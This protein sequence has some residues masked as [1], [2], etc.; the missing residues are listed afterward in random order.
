MEITS[1]RV[2]AAPR[3]A[4]YAAF[5]NPQAVVH[6]WGPHGFTSTIHEFDLRPGG[7]WRFVMRGPDGATYDTVKEFIEVA[8]PARIVFRHLEKMH[9]FTM[10]MI[11][12]TMTANTRL[13]WHMVFEPHPDNAK[14]RPFIVDANE[15]NFD[16]LAAFLQRPRE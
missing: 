14:W 5:A 10:T 3:E 12:E 2:F 1:T 7:F 11:F 4:V 13:T 16:R 15:Q 9:R 6:W 8:P